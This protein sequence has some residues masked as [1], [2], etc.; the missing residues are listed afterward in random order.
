[1]RSRE[2]FLASAFALLLAGVPGEALSDPET[3][4]GTVTELETQPDDS[5]RPIEGAVVT[6]AGPG[7]TPV[8][9]PTDATGAFSVVVEGTGPYSVSVQAKGYAARA[10]RDVTPDSPVS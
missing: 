3:I 4:T 10:L 1:M 8:W 5:H 6:V 2:M 7:Q 9:R